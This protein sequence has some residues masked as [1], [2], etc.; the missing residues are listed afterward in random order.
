L[1]KQEL[2]WIQV[3]L[4]ADPLY[5]PSH[6]PSLALVID[7]FLQLGPEARV[8]VELPYRDKATQDMAE[9]FRIEMENRLFVLLEQG[10]EFGYD[11]WEEHGERISVRCWWGIWTRLQ[12][13]CEKT[14]GKRLQK[15]RDDTGQ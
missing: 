10:E 6:A 8:I 13:A 12:P 14:W 4:A 9:A 2:T 1:D 7:A 15:G 11:D 5:S 3:I